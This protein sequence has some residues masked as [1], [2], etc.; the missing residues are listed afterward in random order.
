MDKSRELTPLANKNPYIGPRPFQREESEQFFGRD[1]EARDLVSLVASERLVVFYAQSGAGKTSLIN[2]RLIPGLEEKGFEVLPSGRLSGEVPKAEV[3]NIFVVNLMISLDQMKESPERFKNLRLSDFLL[4]LVFTGAG[5]SYHPSTEHSEAPD[6]SP[7]TLDLEVKIAPRLLII[8]Q[9]EELFTTHLESWN[10]REDFFIQLAEAMQQDPYLWVVLAMREDHIAEIDQFAG[11]MPGRLRT[12]YYM[13]RLGTDGALQAIT[14]PV[15]D[16][17]PFED[18]AAEEIVKNLRRIRV[19]FDE[20]GQPRFAYEEYVEPVQLQVVCY[21]LWEDLKNQPGEKI[22]LDDFYRRGRG[23]RELGDFVDQALADFYRSTLKD[24]VHQPGPFI[25][26]ERLRRWFEQRLITEAG[27][28]GFVFMGEKE[29]AGIPNPCVQRMEGRLLRG[30]NRAGGMWYELVHDRL[31]NPILRDNENAREVQRSQRLRLA[32][33]SLL[34]VALLSVAIILLL[35]GQTQDYGKFQGTVSAQGITVEAAQQV[36]ANQAMMATQDIGKIQ[37]IVTAQGITAEAAQKVIANQ[38][39]MATQDIRVAATEKFKA[40]STATQLAL[41]LLPVDQL[42]QMITSSNIAER[43]SAAK[44]LGLATASNPDFADQTIKVLLDRIMEPNES[45][46]TVR[47]AAAEALLQISKAAPDKVTP[48][49]KDLSSAKADSDATVREILVDTLGAIAPFV[50]QPESLDLMKTTLY[51]LRQDKSSRVQQAADLVIASMQNVS[52]NDFVGTWINTDPATRSWTTILIS[53]VGMDLRFHIFGSCLPTDCDAGMVQTPYTPGAIIFILNNGF[54][55]RTFTVILEGSIGEL[56]VETFN[57]YIDNSNRTD[58]TD[59]SRFKRVELVVSTPTPLAPATSVPIQGGEQLY[60]AL[61]WDANGLAMI[62][63]L[64]KQVVHTITF[65]SINARYLSVNPIRREVYVSYSNGNIF[66]VIEGATGKII[67]KITDGVGWNSSNS[68]V[69]PDGKQVFLATSGSG[70]IKGNSDENKVLVI[71]PVSIRVTKVIKVGGYDFPKGLEGIVISPDGKW[72]YTCD[73]TRGQ[74]VVIDAAQL[75][76]SSQNTVS[77]NRL[78]GIS[79]S[80]DAVYVLNGSSIVKYD[81]AKWASLWSL[82]VSGWIEKIIEN[83]NKVYVPDKD[84]GQVLAIDAVSGKITSK[85]DAQT[86]SGVALSTD[87]KSVYV[88]S[89]DKN[90]IFIFNSSNGQLIAQIPIQQGK[91]PTD[92]AVLEAKK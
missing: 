53:R 87:G 15:A 41:A 92:L 32:M 63:P 58:Y 81:V 82:Q 6:L 4:K 47:Q 34:F 66:Y 55:V 76:I 80:G 3:E 28:R 27:T 18:K 74:V 9:F 48:F 39:M 36:I 19:G 1:R 5:F 31:V 12:R 65:G 79:S 84:G 85:W 16:L 35:S 70:G 45:E 23:R 25:S 11:C 20:N 90:L 40:Q 43:A 38:A 56:T 30:E 46:P 17:R 8:D 61:F 69:S 51:F 88:S 44:A 75:V 64:S 26:E 42:T 2:T 49:L 62:D 50:R 67:G 91:G 29:T 78:L 59:R 22:T 72:I 33:G 21:Q 57:H 68:V 14:K 83:E 10:K 54:A 86:P 71:D 60:A 77:C 89:T 73:E 37:G 13:H 7:S 24:A 52:I